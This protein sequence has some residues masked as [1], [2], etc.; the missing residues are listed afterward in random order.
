MAK[1]SGPSSGGARA[2]PR[3]LR[4]LQRCRPGTARRSQERCSCTPSKGWATSCSSP[5]SSR[6]H[7]RGSRASSCCSTATGKRWRPS[8][9]ARKVSTASLTAED[10]LARRN[11]RC[12]RVRPVAAASARYRRGSDRRRRVSA[13]PGQPE[14]RLGRA[15]GRMAAAAR[16][17]GVVGLR[18]LRLRLRDAAQVDAR[19]CARAVAVGAGVSFVTLQPGPAGD[20]ASLGPEGARVIDLREH[21]A[22]LRRNGRTH[23]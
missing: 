12:T 3:P 21:H 22:R 15:P 10:A 2:S 6:R 9:R 4:A 18:A 17:T 8:W 14:R 7:A 19:R 13:R 20:P 23:P 5:A 1:A 11:D 16:R